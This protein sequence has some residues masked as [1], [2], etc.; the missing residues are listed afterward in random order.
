[1][2]EPEFIDEILSANAQPLT[3]LERSLTLPVEQFNPIIVRCNYI[4][5]RQQ[6]IQHLRQTS[7]LTIQELHLPEQIVPSL[8]AVIQAEVQEPFPQALMILG[9]ESVQQLDEVLA[10]ANWLRDEFPKQLSFPIVLWVDAI[11][12]EKLNRLAADLKNWQTVSIP[13]V[14]PVDTLIYALQ[15]Y[16][17]WVFARLLQM[18]QACPLNRIL[19]LEAGLSSRTELKFALEDL[20][21]SDRPLTPH[22]QA[23][24]DFLS[25]RDA[26]ARTDMVTA[27][28]YYERSLLF[29]EQ[30]SQAASAPKTEEHIDCVLSPPLRQ[31]ILLLHLGFWWRSD[32]VLQRAT[33]QAS[34][35]QAHTYFERCLAMFRQAQ[36]LDLVAIF[37]PALEEVLQ[38]LEDWTALQR[39]ATEA[40]ALHTGTDPVRL[41]R[42]YGFLSE[43]ALAQAQ[44][45][46]ANRWVNRA[47]ELLNLTPDESFPRQSDPVEIVSLIPLE[48]LQAISLQRLRDGFEVIQQYYMGWFLFLQGRSQAGLGHRQEAITSLLT[49]LDISEPR[50]DPPMYIRILRELRSLFFAEGQY[51]E[52]FQIKQLRQQIEQQFGL[53]A[54]AGAGRLVTQRFTMPAERLPSSPEEIVNIEIATSG[55]QRDVERLISR[56]STPRDKLTVIHGAS[57]V[58]KSSILSAGLVPALRH[59]TIEARRILSLMLSVYNDWCGTLTE[60]L[61][62]GLKELNLGDA[63]DNPPPLPPRAFSMAYSVIPTAHCISHLLHQ[64]KQNQHQNLYTVLILD[65]FEEF[66]FVWPELSQRKAFYTFLRDCLNIPYLKVILSIREDYLHYLL[67]VDRVADLEVISNDILSKQIRYPLGDFSPADA[68]A[69]IHRLTERSQFYLE[70]GLIDALVQDLTGESEGVRPIELQIVGAQLQRDSIDTLEEYR[71]LGQRPKQTLVQRYLQQTIEDCGRENEAVAQLVLFLLTQEDE[72]RPFKTRSEL[73]DELSL[74]HIPFTSDQL[75]LILEILTGSGLVLKIPESPTELYQLVHDYLVSYIREQQRSDLLAELDQERSQRIETQKLTRQ[76]HQRQG[77]RV[78]LNQKIKQKLWLQ[79]CAIVILFILLIAS[80]MVK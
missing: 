58:G 64:L 14:L 62:E 48:L 50:Y 47:V 7:S 39:V 22:L 53:R 46:E 59:R 75:D 67:E 26:H 69:V 65:Q 55:R 40:I 24:L 15:T 13:F 35:Q 66:F 33:V 38:K 51:L 70:A 11:G 63:E 1:M 10:R 29:W 30:Q 12:F 45:A 23:H 20:T 54:F 73:A 49:A 2:T 6:I 42:D 68:K 76:K 32:A 57:G 44:F 60:L 3:A 41:A 18:E 80:L 71:Q 19:N 72:T 4:W 56:V 8:F 5:L 61:V 9:L 79:Q 25:G 74:L 37:I 16:A 17:D 34:C 36:R 31:A 28:S 27:R 52:A 77:T 43:V 21:K 78:R